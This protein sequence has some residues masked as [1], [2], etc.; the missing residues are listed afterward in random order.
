MTTYKLSPIAL[1]SNL[2]LDTEATSVAYY[3]RA[4]AWKASGMDLTKTISKEVVRV[5]KEHQSATHDERLPFQ[6]LA[7]EIVK[8]IRA[9]VPGTSHSAAVR[10][11]ASVVEAMRADGMVSSR[12]GRGG[13]LALHRAKPKPAT[14][15]DILTPELR[16][17]LKRF[18][19]FQ[20]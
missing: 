1:T 9:E 6:A 5:L 10:Q 15:G 18:P 7:Q 14:T 12:V 20:Y 13:G 16:E 17:A 4:K 19:G 2:A 3:D 8:K 11:V